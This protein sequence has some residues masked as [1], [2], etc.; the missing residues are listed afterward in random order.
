MKKSEDIVDFLFLVH[1]WYDWVMGTQVLR[2][3]HLFPEFD[4]AIGRPGYLTQLLQGDLDYGRAIQSIGDFAETTFKQPETYDPS[5]LR[6][7]IEELAPSFQAYFA[8]LIGTLM[9]I[10]SVCGARGGEADVRANRLLNGHVQFEK[11]LKDCLDKYTVQPMMLQTRDT[12]FEG[13]NTWPGLSVPAVHAV[14][15][16]LSPRHARSWR[17]LPCDAWGK[18]REL[19]FLGDER[20]KPRGSRKFMPTP[21]PESSRASMSG[22]SVML[23]YYT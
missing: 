1:S 11:Y 20:G 9:A 7:R 19:P 8:E 2:Q 5:L 4:D 22:A 12:T 10:P 13:G 21:D 15:D 18:P 17:F 14:V 6:R 3:K 23:P 16:R